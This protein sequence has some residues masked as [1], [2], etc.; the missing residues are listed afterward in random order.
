MHGERVPYGSG[1]RPIA[2]TIE[3][4][5]AAL[6]EA[7]LTH[8]SDGAY[9]PAVEGVLDEFIGRVADAF[10]CDGWD[11]LVHWVEQTCRSRA[12]SKS[13]HRLFTTAPTVLT[14]AFCDFDEAPFPHLAR[15]AGTAKRMAAI[16]R[17]HC[18]GR[19]SAPHPMVDC[20]DV[21]VT[22]LLNE[23]YAV[24]RPAG[25]HSRAVSQWCR[26]IALR[27]RVPA[28]I[29]LKTMRGGL[30][31][32]IGRISTP[33]ELLSAARPLSDQE[34]QIV[35]Q[36]VHAGQ[37][38]LRN[39]ARLSELIPFVRHHHE[40]YD[41]S[42]YP[43]GLSGERI[44]LGVRIVTVADAFNAMISHKPY[45]PAM[46]PEEAVDELQRCKAT[47]FDPSI[48]DAMVEVV[49]ERAG[50]TLLRCERA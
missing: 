2:R 11:D 33:S 7:V 5:R 14:N 3:K 31:H 46:R 10:A 49:T 22:D 27:L 26:D 25:E 8:L 44:P 48:V 16:A 39:S 24:D 9:A 20:V 45:R 1:C 17:E 4:R 47:Q 23:L 35:R 13:M 38:I 37:V 21:V 41:G 6:A 36:H 30:V 43:E 29:A 50:D 12:Q 15:F 42:G 28:H 19:I 34:R 18:S 32:D 40:W